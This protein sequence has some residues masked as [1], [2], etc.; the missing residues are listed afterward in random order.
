MQRGGEERGSGEERAAGR[1][2]DADDPRAR[3]RHAATNGVYTRQRQVEAEL[4]SVQSGPSHVAIRALPRVAARFDPRSL[5]P[6]A[7]ASGA[8]HLNLESIWKIEA[9]K[10]IK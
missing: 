1:S 8:P 2:R 10:S 5:C 3:R 9:N 4:I 6:V 7:S